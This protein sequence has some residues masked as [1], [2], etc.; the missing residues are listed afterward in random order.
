MVIR[1]WGILRAD[2]AGLGDVGKAAAILQQAHRLVRPVEFDRVLQQVGLADYT[3]VRVDLQR[4]HVGLDPDPIS[5]GA[6]TGAGLVTSRGG[7]TAPRGRPAGG[8]QIVGRAVVP[9]RLFGRL[10]DVAAL[11]RGL[12]LS[13]P[14]L[15]Q[16]DQDEAQGDDQDQ[17]ALFHGNLSVSRLNGM[18]PVM[19]IGSGSV[20]FGVAAGAAGLRSG[21]GHRIDATGAK[22]MAASQ[23]TQGQPATLECTV[24]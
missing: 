20:G 18:G 15:P 17:A 7:H 5:R 2:Q 19:G 23:S 10:G 13:Q 24:L 21:A 14:G 1:G 9:S 4:Q 6:R 11:G 16:Q 12:V 8:R 22:G 3:A